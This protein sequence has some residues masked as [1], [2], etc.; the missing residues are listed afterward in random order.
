MDLNSNELDAIFVLE[1]VAHVQVNGNLPSL[2][3]DNFQIL[4]EGVQNFML[5]YHESKE[6]SDNANMS[7][8][9]SV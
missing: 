8:D 3:I 5:T 2:N 1:V 7:K 4:S 6:D 9:N